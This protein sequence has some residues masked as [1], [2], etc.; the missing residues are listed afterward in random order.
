MSNYIFGVE[1][2]AEST[3]VYYELQRVSGGGG[4]GWKSEE[5]RSV[6]GGV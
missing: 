2:K 5:D 6:M 1:K 3:E 4:T